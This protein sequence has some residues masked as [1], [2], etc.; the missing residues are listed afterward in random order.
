MGPKMG[1]FYCTVLYILQYTLYCVQ[2]QGKQD[3]WSGLVIPYASFFFF[4]K[5]ETKKIYKSKSID[6]DDKKVVIS[7][8]V[9]KMRWQRPKKFLQIS[10]YKPPE[11]PFGGLKRLVP[12][13][14]RKIDRKE[15]WRTIRS[16]GSKSTKN[17]K[18][19]IAKKV[20]ESTNFKKGLYRMP[21]D[22][23]FST[24]EGLAVRGQGL[25]IGPIF[26]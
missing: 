16:E 25:E 26:R 2:L 7:L 11:M 10:L 5:I 19:Q 8:E 21:R 1:V 15:Y 4:R 23:H 18:K 13:K 14:T 6:Y 9:E 24:R 22:C 12:L 17:R 20:F 3:K